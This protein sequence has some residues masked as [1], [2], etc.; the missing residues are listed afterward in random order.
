LFYFITSYPLLLS[1]MSI[2]LALFLFF[3]EVYSL[4][5]LA[6]TGLQ[7][8]FSIIFFYS[9]TYIWLFISLELSLFP[10]LF[11]VLGYGMQLEKISATYYLLLYTLVGAL[12]LL[13]VISYLGVSERL[14]RK[15]KLSREIK[16]FISLPFLVKFP[17]YL[18]HLWL[19]KAHLEASTLGSILL[20]S[21]LLKL[22]RIGYLFISTSILSRV[23]LLVRLVGISWGSLITL[24]QSDSKA[25]VGYSSVVHMRAVLLGLEIGNRRGVW[26]GL[27][28]ILSH[29]FVSGSLFYL[30]GRLFHLKGTRIIYLLNSISTSSFF[31]LLFSFSF[32]GN[33]GIPPLIRFLGEV[34]LLR[35]RINLIALFLLFLGGYLLIAFYYSLYLLVSLL[36]GKRGFIEGESYFS[37]STLLA[38]VVLIPLL[39]LI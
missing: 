25:L 33:M 18:F 5:L 28:L 7:L 31:F 27:L 15:R 1:L 30:V 29:S 39:P 32:L 36:V 14:E 24:F 10:I 11:L 37:S 16:L 12:P 17:I 34:S 35:R 20:A 21:I 22:G 6:L 19:P 26:G 8:F 3:N 38:I 9:T 13:V 4:S 23:V 2:I